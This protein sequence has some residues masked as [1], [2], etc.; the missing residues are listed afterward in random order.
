M[1][2]GIE[3]IKNGRFT[4]LFLAVASI[5]ILFLFIK[6]MND[7]AASLGAPPEQPEISA[8]VGNAEDSPV[9][10]AYIDPLC[11]R[12]K[13]YHE[14]TLV[15]IKEN[16]V[17]SNKLRLEVRLLSIIA[18]E[19]AP[20]VEFAMCGHD[21]GVFWD[22]L[23]LLYERL[24]RDNDKSSVDNANRFFKDYSSAELAKAIGADAKKLDAC[25]SDGRY[26]TKLEK[27]NIAAQEGGVTS[28]P[29]TFIRGTDPLRGYVTFDQ[30]K[31]LLDQVK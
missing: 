18:R 3:D 14:D 4:T 13:E 9:I 25:L 26:K 23:S 29:S 2:N 22:S 1:K 17:D 16:Y 5:I 27:S 30:I 20:L 19:S 12:C 28:T 8:T 31:P 11:P 24:Y 6:H 10:V 15:K 21:Q 7:S